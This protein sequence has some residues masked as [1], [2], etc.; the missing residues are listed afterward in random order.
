MNG[1]RKAQRRRKEGVGPK[2]R[3]GEGEGRIPAPTGFRQE[4]T[5]DGI[6]AKLE[7]LWRFLA[8]EV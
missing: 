6:V 3:V 1:E 7:S 8:G 5:N 4:W 2:V